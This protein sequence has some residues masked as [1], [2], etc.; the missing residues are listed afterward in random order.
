VGAVAAPPAAPG[1]TDGTVVAVVPPPAGPATVVT[2]VA[3]V[4]PPAA[5]P[6][7]PTSGWKGFLV[8]FSSKLSAGAPPGVVVVVVGTAVAPGAGAGVA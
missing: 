6:V 5:P 8:K 3:V 2:G 4:A 7:A 1:E